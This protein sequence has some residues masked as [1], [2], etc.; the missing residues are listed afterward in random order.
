MPVFF[1]ASGK[2]CGAERAPRLLQR[3]A[4]PTGHA[5]MHCLETTNLI[6]RYSNGD[7]VLDDVHL[8]I[9]EKSIYGFL[10]PNGAGKT[11]TLRLIL[12]LLRR[13]QGTIS[14]FGKSFDAHRTE[15]L[16]N[17]GSLIES[18]SLYDHL[19]SRENLV[20]LQKIHRIPTARIGN[21]LELVGLSHT[22]SKK[23]GEFSLGMKQRLSIAI[24]LLHRPSLL[25]LDE[26][27]NGLDPHGIVE[28]R[29]LLIR[30]NR[31]DGTTIMISSHLLSEIERLVTHVGIIHRGRMRFQG[32]LEALRQ[33]RRQIAAITLR[34]SDDR[35]ALHIVSKDVQG[36]RFVDGRIV[37]PAMSNAQIASV[38]RCLV[39]HG[40]DVHALGTVGDDLE[41]IFM[42]MV[43]N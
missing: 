22:G 42:D 40:V 5:P 34:T 36:A 30:L 28:M 41:A 10:G 7:L 6:H 13:Q 20:V 14:I 35:R 29:D 33:R 38:N 32:P 8:Q 3:I 12:G 4:N 43:A 25:I 31:E 2:G 37:M 16:R 21:V 19:T 26:P 39:G 23:V 1:T 11:T 27:T 15:I 17:I 24:A 9:P 18:P